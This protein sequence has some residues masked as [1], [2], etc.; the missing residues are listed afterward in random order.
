MGEPVGET[1]GY[2]VR[3]E[4]VSGPRTR[5]LF[6]TEGMLTRRL[7]SDP[8]LKGVDCVVLDEFHERHW[9]RILRSRLLKRIGKRMVVMSATLDAAP[10]ALLSWGLSGGTQRRAG[11]FR[12]RSI[13][14]RTRLRRWKSRCARG[15]S[16][17]LSGTTSGDVL[18][19]LPGAAEIRRCARTLEPVAARRD[20]LITPLHGDLSPAEQDQRGHA[21]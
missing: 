4:D 9:T 12:S 14:R 18:V 1:V 5:L 3:F 10:V 2:Q 19:F 15:W 17:L 8:Q 16:G 20:L 7:L 6:L 11:S 13:T 21:C